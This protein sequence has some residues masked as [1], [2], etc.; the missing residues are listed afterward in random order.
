[1]AD[2]KR[3]QHDE[4]LSEKDIT[5]DGEVQAAESLNGERGREISK[6]EWWQRRLLDLSLKNNAI[7]FRFRRDCL[8]IYSADVSAFTAALEHCNKYTLFST[9]SPER[10]KFG[11]LSVRNSAEII[12]LELKSA[13]MRC[14]TPSDGLEEVAASLIRKARSGEEEGGA[15]T[16]YLALGFLKWRAS[17]DKEDRYAPIVLM[18]VK[19]RRNRNLGIIL[20]TGEEYEVNEALIEFLKREFEI[21]LRGAHFKGLSPKEIICA[22]SAKTAHITGCFVYEDIYLAQFTFARYAMWA[23]IKNNINTFRQNPLVASLIDEKNR[24]FN[25][26]PESISEDG[27]DPSAVLAPLPCDS[28]QFSAIAESARGA[29]FVL[30]GPPGTGKSQTIANIIANGLGSGKRVLFVAQKQAALQVVKKRLDDIGLGDFCMELHSGKT[31]NKG[32]IIGSIENTLALTSSFDGGAYLSASE[33]IKEVRRCLQEPFNAL[34]RKRRLGVSV[35]EGI[36]N[37][38]ND[39]DAPDIVKAE[40]SFY[41][42][43]TQ[44]RLEEYESMLVTAQAAA[45]ECGGVHCSPFKEVNLTECDK[46]TGL[47]VLCSAKAV[48]SELKHLKSSLDFFLEIF[49]RKISRLTFKKLEKLTDI[50]KTLQGGE[51]SFFFDCDEGR[52]HKFYNASLIYDRETERWFKK[53]KSFPDVSKF[54][55]EMKS[56]MRKWGENYRSSRVLLSVLKKINRCATQPLNLDEELVWMKRAYGIEKAKQELLSVRELSSAFTGFGGINEKKRA[57]FMSPLYA[58]NDLCIETFTDYNADSFFSVCVNYGQALEPV[59]KEFLSSSARFKDCIREHREIIHAEGIPAEADLFDYY[60]KK[61]SALIENIDMLPAWCKYRATAKKLNECGL[62]FTPD[63]A[64]GGKAGGERIL[65]SLRKSV[66]RNFVQTSIAADE[67]LS[68]F[69]AGVLQENAASYS[70]LLEEFYDLTRQKIRASLISRLSSVQ[71]DDTLAFETANFH[72]KIKGNL[73]KFKL[74]ELFYEIPGLLKVVS[75]CVLMSPETVSRFL[76]ADTELFDLVIF[77]EA[78]QIPTCEAVPALARAKS[79]II[80]GDPKQM[81]PTTFFSGTVQDEEYPQ[82]QDLESVLED[83]IALGIP[84][85]HLIW[86]YR[87]KHESL[88]A[89]S[90]LMYY[91]GRLCTFPSPDALNSKVSLKYIENGVYER[92]GTKCNRAEAEAL[93]K[94]VIDRL[95]DEKLRNMSIGI[96]TFSTPQQLLIE[97]LLTKAII[98]N[99]LEEIAYEREEPV[100]VKNLESVQGDERDVILFSVCYGPDK[101]GKVSLNF[102]PLNGFGGWRRLNVAVSRARE[103]MV[104]FSSMKF[105]MID[106]SRTGSRG[107]AGLKAFLEFAEKG[108]AGLLSKSEET[109]SVGQSINKFVAKE[110]KACGYGCKCDVGVS[111]FKI[112]IAVLDPRN[113]NN[114]VLAIITDGTDKFSVKDREVMQIQALKRGGW[115]V[116]KLHT[117]S[118][119]NN[120]KREIKKIKELLD[121][122]TRGNAPAP[123]NFKSPYRSA[124]FNRKEQPPAYILGGGHDGEV[125]RVIKRVVEVEEPVSEQFLIKRTLSAYGIKNCGIRL[126][127]KL[128]KLIGECNFSSCEMMGNTYIYRTEKHFKFNKF[129]VEENGFLRS[130]DTDYTPFDIISLVKAMLANKVSMYQDELVPTVLKELKVPKTSAKLV[131]LVNS[132]VEEGVRRGLFIKS[133]SDRISLT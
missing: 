110:L 27:M 124:K 99:R 89:F 59:I 131:K 80:V 119:F 69:S 98:A 84:Q 91:S 7:N 114:F 19:L 78:S 93:V 49:N 73:R 5:D 109:K 112:D 126:E 74:R 44:N 54:M 38:L 67:S 87:S 129:R 60:T 95:K 128:K 107:V 1:M 13:K 105:S 92:G 2:I 77:D 61:C 30:H 117:I 122:L 51:L 102:G 12:D 24:L 103:E 65:S 6:E 86:H 72:R 118:F 81:P 123:L 26:K 85:K 100:F 45:R 32:E 25:D 96:V 58:F 22:F 82:S 79:A 46:R 53:F 63:G 21:D 9:P 64:E 90:N 33:K 4:V 11:D 14:Y 29:T 115:N 75:P 56:E 23:D 116:Y 66:Y 36:V 120:P 18:P 108:T 133:A 3:Q 55:P 88:I 83:C 20:E 104:V 37:C 70:A 52:L 50:C 34:H 35:C 101:R 121:G 132:C 130:A 31:A 41:D 48:L 16:L 76:P 62:T 113:K 68:S 71:T 40:S 28:A 43:L 8:H 39:K 127:K 15:N 42:G 17:I 94:E 106:L 97:K 125:M 47:S 57:F 111:D 10:A